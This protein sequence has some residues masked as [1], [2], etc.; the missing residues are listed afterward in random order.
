MSS[1]D[2]TDANLVDVINTVLPFEKHLPGMNYC[3][4]GTDLK[5]RLQPDGTTPKPGHEPV[6]RVDR[7]A[8]KHDLAYNNH[9][10]LAERLNADKEMIEDLKRIQNPSTRE[11]CYHSGIV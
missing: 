6:D 5:K 1:V 3:G 10:G 2:Q 9:S 7:A 8:L 4:P 11:R